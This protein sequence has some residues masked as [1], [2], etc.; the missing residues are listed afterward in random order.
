MWNENVF[1]SLEQ[2]QAHFICLK[3]IERK[4]PPKAEEAGKLHGYFERIA[5]PRMNAAL[6]VKVTACIQVQVEG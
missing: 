2:V 3:Q 6:G 4:G 1:P 5:N